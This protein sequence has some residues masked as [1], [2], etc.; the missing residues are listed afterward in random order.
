MNSLIKTLKDQGKGR[1]FCFIQEKKSAY[2]F[3]LEKLEN[4]FVSNSRIL[5]IETPTV[6]NDNWLLISEETLKKLE[7]LGIRQASFVGFAATTSICQHIGL[8]NNKLTRSLVL[9]NP[10][11]RPNP[12][13]A[14]KIIDRLEN[15]LPLGLPLRQKT[16]NFDSKPFLQRLRSPLLILTTN[17]VD[18][19]TA[20]ESQL[21]LKRVPTSWHFQLS[22]DQPELQASE[23]INE[24]ENVPVKCP[25]KN[26]TKTN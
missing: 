25:Q 21:M 18:H 26:L 8:I 22:K 14:Q 3:S 6:T 19:Y 16:K 11:T 10:M 7:D 12:T 4:S 24:F 1:A 17:D 9:I 15:F 23:L 5:V 13:A 20:R 2:T